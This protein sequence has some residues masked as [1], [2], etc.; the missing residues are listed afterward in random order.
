MNHKLIFNVEPVLCTNLL[1]WF[2]KDVVK[3]EDAILDLLFNTSKVRYILAL[4]L[5]SITDNWCI[6]LIAT[7]SIR[8]QAIGFSP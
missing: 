1:T 4:P 8:Y 7:C 3:D 2:N 5:L 6:I